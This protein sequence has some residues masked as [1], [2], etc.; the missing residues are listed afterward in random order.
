[1]RV[2]VS[3]SF[4]MRMVLHRW[5]CLWGLCMG[6]RAGQWKSWWMQHP[7]QPTLSFLRRYF[8]PAYTLWDFYEICT[9][10]TSELERNVHNTTLHFTYSYEA[11]LKCNV[12]FIKEAPSSWPSIFS[13]T[14]GR[15]SARLLFYC[16][17]RCSSTAKPAYEDGTRWVF[18]LQKDCQ[19]GTSLRFGFPISAAVCCGARFSIL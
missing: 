18:H 4:V 12:P 15:L 9:H 2:S 5:V 19:S 10:K 13:E 11:L 16:L 1:M 17:F 14:F 7:R 6:Q 3:S 8:G